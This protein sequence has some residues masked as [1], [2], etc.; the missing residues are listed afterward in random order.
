MPAKQGSRSSVEQ[1]HIVAVH[2][3][4]AWVRQQ[5][6]AAVQRG[7]LRRLKQGAGRAVHHKGWR[8]ASACACR[9]QSQRACW[10][11]LS[12]VTIRNRAGTP[13][14]PAKRCGGLHAPRR[15]ISSAL[16]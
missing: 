10:G 15:P 3:G 11:M 6:L 14:T 16:L 8:V 2:G 13:A 5:V 4:T 12:L 1:P 9:H 7:L